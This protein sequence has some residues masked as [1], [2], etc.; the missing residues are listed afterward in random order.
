MKSNILPQVLGWVSGD[1]AVED[2]ELGVCSDI[3]GNGNFEDHDMDSG[4]DESGIDE[5]KTVDSDGG[6]DRWQDWWYD[7]SPLSNC[8]GVGS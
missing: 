3:I 7:H 6:D 4:S 1:C 5:A 2:E 8:N